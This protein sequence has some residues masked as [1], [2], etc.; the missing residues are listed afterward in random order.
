M[1]SSK[2]KKGDKVSYNGN[3][4]NITDFSMNRNTGVWVYE[5]DGE[6]LVYESELTKASKAKNNPQS[7]KPRSSK[8]KKQKFQE[9]DSV[10]VYNF[11]GNPYTG[12]IKDVKSTQTSNEY[13]VV[14]DGQDRWIE[15]KSLYLADKKAHGNT[16]KIMEVQKVI[17][18]F[19]GLEGQEVPKRDLVNF[20]TDIKAKIDN[21]EIRKH[22]NGSE[23]VNRIQNWLIKKVNA[24]KNGESLTVKFGNEQNDM[25]EFYSSEKED[26]RVYNTLDYAK[27]VYNLAKEANKDVSEIKSKTVLNAV[28]KIMNRGNYDIA[29][30]YDIYIREKAVKLLES[31]ESKIAVLKKERVFEDFE[32]SLSRLRTFANGGTTFKLAKSTLHGPVGASE[33]KKKQTYA[34]SQMK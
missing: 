16:L 33:S 31:I 29:E 27:K 8:P 32:P 26:N 24:M 5:L 6:Q 2:F 10:G 22:H 14:G 25:K 34:P 18:K 3:E 13:R 21:Y 19:L 7:D 4:Y 9:G 1:A 30:A 17:A 23:Y 11:A 12:K 20:L 15:E 28:D